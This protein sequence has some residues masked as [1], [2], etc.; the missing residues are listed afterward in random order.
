MRTSPARLPIKLPSRLKAGQ[1]ALTLLPTDFTG[2]APLPKTPIS[3]A[4]L[5]IPPHVIE[6]TQQNGSAPAHVLGRASPH[7]S[8]RFGFTVAAFVSFERRV[9]MRV[10]DDQMSLRTPLLT[11]LKKCSHRRDS[12]FGPKQRS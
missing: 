5:E 4:E 6:P 7:R 12:R 3:E 2:M 10:Y 9:I 8:Q 1:S 11:M